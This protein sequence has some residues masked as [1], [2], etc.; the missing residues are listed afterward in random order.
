MGAGHWER[1]RACE[2]GSFG[3]GCPYLPEVGGDSQDTT[4]AFVGVGCQ[5]VNVGE[6]KALGGVLD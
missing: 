4:E 1:G 5:C 3:E 2:G 6:V